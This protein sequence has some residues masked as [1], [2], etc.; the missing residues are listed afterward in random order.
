MSGKW[1]KAFTVF[2]FISLLAISLA[3]A[4]FQQPVI[5]I[6]QEAFAEFDQLDNTISFNNDQAVVSSQ[7]LRILANWSFNCKGVSDYLLTKDEFAKFRSVYFIQQ[8]KGRNPLLGRPLKSLTEDYK[9]VF[10]GD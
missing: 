1:L 9:K 2:V 10:A 4:L 5:S 8:I 7:D 3:L 6:S